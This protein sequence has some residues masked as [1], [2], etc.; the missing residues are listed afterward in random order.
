MQQKKKEGPHGGPSFYL[1]TPDLN[2]TLVCPNLRLVFPSPPVNRSKK[3]RVTASQAEAERACGSRRASLNGGGCD[4]V[5]RHAAWM[6]CPTIPAPEIAGRR[7]VSRGKA[8]R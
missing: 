6:G 1:Q 2:W 4:D 3:W 5:L 7:K 8:L